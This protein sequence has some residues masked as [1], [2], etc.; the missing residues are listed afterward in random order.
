MKSFNE[1]LKESSLSRVLHHTEKSNI[2]M[3]SASRAENTPEQNKKNNKSLEKDIRAH[4]HGVVHVTGHYTEN[5][6]TP[7]EKHVKEHSMLVIGKKGSDSSELLNH[8][9]A[10]GSKYNQDSVLHKAKGDEHAHLHGT[11]E[12]SWPGLGQTHNVGH[13]HPNRAAEFTSHLKGNRSFT[14]SESDETKFL[15]DE[16]YFKALE[17]AE[18][19]YDIK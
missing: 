17:K 1:F 16:N 3:I 2:G 18:L 7:E 6:G 19:M 4:G 12:G 5:K 9:K 14:F 8:L 11:K 10:L 13:F 15:L